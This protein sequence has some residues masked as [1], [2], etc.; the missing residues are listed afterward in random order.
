MQQIPY[1]QL[2][3][4]IPDMPARPAV[5]PMLPTRVR[6]PGR[7][8]PLP[9]A[10]AVRQCSVPDTAPPYDDELQAGQDLPEPPGEPAPDWAE[11]G[12]TRG[13]QDRAERNHD[14]DHSPPPPGQAGNWPSQFAQVLAE[15]LA[16]SRPARQLTP[17]TSEQAR[18]RIRQLGP[19]LATE[20]R[21]R[22]RRVV[23]SAPAT[24]VLELA[25]VVGFGP[26]VRL[27]AIRLER[28]QPRPYRPG[29]G[30][31]CTAIESA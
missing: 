29:G 28:D 23:T 18:R 26:R 12:V 9:D 21:P 3:W 25:A 14:H 31:C 24:D 22:V 4:H 11:P 17:W 19:L 13:S 2:P 6:Q 10:V 5:V 15:T 16:G 7:Q 20:Q 1:P 8:A 30:W 27:L